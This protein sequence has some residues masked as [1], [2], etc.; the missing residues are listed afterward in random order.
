[1]F[2]FALIFAHGWLTACDGFYGASAYR[3][4]PMKQKTI[5]ITMHLVGHTSSMELTPL[6]S[7]SKLL[8]LHDVY[9]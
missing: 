7:V 6:W 2:S 9:V 4:S 5:T 3:L 1:V 8:F